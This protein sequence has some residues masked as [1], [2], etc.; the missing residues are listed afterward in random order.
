[1]IYIHSLELPLFRT[2]FHSPKGVRAIEVRLNFLPDKTNQQL[3]KT[4]LTAVKFT[5]FWLLLTNYT[6]AKHLK[7]QK[8]W[9]YVVTFF[10]LCNL[11]T[12]S[13]SY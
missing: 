2:Y 5:V 13:G 9:G 4:L 1:M 10:F 7:I 12:C 11:I 6:S 8:I 3:K